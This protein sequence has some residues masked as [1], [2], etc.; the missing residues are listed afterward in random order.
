MAKNLEKLEANLKRNPD[1][2]KG[3]LGGSPLTMVGKIK[4]LKM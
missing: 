4:K 2:L 1:N 3:T